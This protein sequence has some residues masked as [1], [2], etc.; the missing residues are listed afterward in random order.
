MLN[1]LR[2][3][4]RLES[5]KPSDFFSEEALARIKEAVGEAEKKTSGEIRVVV[6]QKCD[7]LDSRIQALME[8][9][10]AG[11]QN[12]RDKTGVLILLA[13]RE[14]KFEIVADEG[15]NAKIV[16]EEWQKLS[17]DM[18]QYFRDGLFAEGVLLAVNRVGHELAEHFPR[19]SDDINELPDDVILGGGQ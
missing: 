15:I 5:D 4:L 17:A 1:S 2:R 7:Y 12:T 14:R 10:R 11:M 16:P 9:E 6:L 3:L 8:F 13:L 19:K 18:A